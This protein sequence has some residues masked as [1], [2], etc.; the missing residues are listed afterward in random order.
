MKPGFR[1]IQACSAYYHPPMVRL[2][3]SAR[4]VAKAVGWSSVAGLAVVLAGLASLPM[5]PLHL[6]LL[7]FAGCAAGLS[8]RAAARTD[9]A[10]PRKAGDALEALSKPLLMVKHAQLVITAGNR[11][12]T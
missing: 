3:K 2:L 8:Y 12:L 11:A 7:F 4:R 1:V 10:G 5:S 9:R 6:L